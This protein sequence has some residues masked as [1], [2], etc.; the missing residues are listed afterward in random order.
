M[1]ER[2]E[3]PCFLRV[4]AF[5]APSMA[6]LLSGCG[7]TSLGLPFQNDTEGGTAGSAGTTAGGSYGGGFMGGGVGVAGGGS[8]AV[9]GGSGFGGSMPVAGGK[10]DGGHPSVCLLAPND[11]R[12][13]TETACELSN[14]PCRGELLQSTIM[15][16]SQ[17][18]SVLALAPGLD[19]GVV[20][21]GNVVGS[22]DFGGDVAPLEATTEE[23]FDGHSGAAFVTSFA[24]DGAVQWAHALD[25]PGPQTPRGLGVTSSGLVIAT[26]QGSSDP[27]NPA[28]LTAVDADGVRFRHALGSA[29]PT[30][31]AI[32]DNDDEIWAAGVFNSAFTYRGH[33]LETTGGARGYLLRV[34]EKGDAIESKATMHDG[35]TGTSISRLLVDTEGQL[36]IAGTRAGP[37][38]P[39]VFLQKQSKSGVVAFTKHW[40]V[41]TMLTALRVA[42]DRKQR[43][44][45]ARSFEGTF[46]SEG[47]TFKAGKDSSAVWLA[48]YSSTGELSWQQTFPTSGRDATASALV[49]DAFDNL[50]LLGRADRII[51]HDRSAQPLPEHGRSVEYVV[52]LRADGAVAWLRWFDGEVA[53]GAVTTDTDGRVWLGGRA[54]SHF[55]Y[56]ESAP[57]TTNAPGAIV[58]QLGP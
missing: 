48:Q 22:L 5:L 28:F 7:R 39:Q 42:V 23:D 41:D 33:T 17:W 8:A 55:W 16:S 49:T 52:K 31:V 19:G 45:V 29:S 14:L 37:G 36:I 18:A 30:A 32:D 25:G 10:A 44:T 12:L 56:D 4:A 58:L 11:C 51:V 2:A 57:D 26:V 35:F 20:A 13:D 21:A 9:S 40:S 47:E 24:A 27:I 43:V 34:D 38:G 3:L 1:V 15:R 46:E 50:L 53:L 54:Y 6:L